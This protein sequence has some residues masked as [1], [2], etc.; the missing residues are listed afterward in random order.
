M[1]ADVDQ[2]KKIGKD[3][4]PDLMK[5]FNDDQKDALNKLKKS[6]K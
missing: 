1:L 5:Y 3:I 2:M 6:I 4:D